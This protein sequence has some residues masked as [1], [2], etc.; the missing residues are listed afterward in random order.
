VNREF[1]VEVRGD[2]A[3]VLLSGEIDML[4]APAVRR[5]IDRALSA[6]AS[7]VVINLDAVTFMDSTGLGAI[8]IGYRAAERLGRGYRLGPAGVPII[9]RT[10][11][12]TGLDSLVLEPSMD[13]E[14]EASG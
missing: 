14:S 1:L 3:Y 4:A 6:P 13:S 9:A 5:A 2:A 7:G 8:I 10:L 11:A 12:V